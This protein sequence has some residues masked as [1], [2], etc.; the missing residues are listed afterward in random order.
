[1]MSGAGVASTPNW[2]ALLQAR[3]RTGRVALHIDG[4]EMTYRELWLRS[5]DLASVLVGLGL[6]PGER[7]FMLAPNS[8]EWVIW[9]LACALSGG[10]YV[11]VATRW[12]RREIEH[13]LLE[14]RPSV[15]VTDDQAR[16]NPLADTILDIVHR[17]WGPVAHGSLPQATVQDAGLRCIVGVGGASGRSELISVDALTTETRRAPTGEV[18]R[19][20][21]AIDPMFPAQIQYTS[22]TTAFPKGAV[23]PHGGLTRS[24]VATAQRM[25]LEPD[26][27]QFSPQP[28]FYAGGLTAGLLVGLVAGCTTFSQTFFEPRQALDIIEQFS[29]THHHGVGTMYVMEYEH[30]TFR[31]DRVSSMTVMRTVDNAEASRRHYAAMG[32]RPTNVYGLT[33]A[34]ANVALADHREPLDWALETCG[35]PMPGVELRIKD[36]HG[37]LVGADQVGEVEVRGNVMLGYWDPKVNGP[38]ATDALLPDGW[39]RTG[40]L[41]AIDDLGRFHFV[42]RTKEIIRVGSQNVS[43]TEVEDVLCYH[44]DVLHAVAFGVPDFHLDEVVGVAVQLRPGSVAKDE[45]LLGFVRQQI[46]SYKV[47]R[48]LWRVEHL[49][50]TPGLK[51]N[52]GEV[53]S[54]FVQKSNLDKAGS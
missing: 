44:P 32:G 18:L 33:E 37:S 21:S 6:L 15:I 26:S 47:P 30:P 3:S 46:A 10:I 27:R 50:L 7:V 2:T 22:G 23:L 45:D 42:G 48:Y 53:R 39:L 28:F 24:A 54:T 1:M 25:G 31:R 19:R 38:A 34:C 17:E 16:N 20:A 29:C 41:G 35:R 11:P 12:K 9:M 13:V 40:D 52:R 43:P 4:R 51:I 8:C 14:C 5:R 49:P 36:A